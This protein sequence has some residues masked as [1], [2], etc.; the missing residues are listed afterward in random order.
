MRNYCESIEDVVRLLRQHG[1]SPTR[2]RVVIARVLFSRAQHL[3]AE[4]IW[5]LANGQDPA[6][7]KATV[8]NT[9]NLLSE[10]GLIREVIARPGKV[11]YDSNTSPHHH[12][13]DVNSGMLTDIRSEEIELS[14]LPDLPADVVAEGV[15]I[16]VRVRTK[17]KS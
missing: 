4:E 15:E 12:F 6:T 11:Y 10:R 2:Q 3:A 7:S 5:E 9:L 8:Y 17:T 13:Y 14:R 16:I 1:V